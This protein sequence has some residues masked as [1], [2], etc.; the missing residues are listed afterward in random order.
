MSFLEIFGR[1]RNDDPDTSKEAA[2]SI[3]TAH[4]ELLVLGVVKRHKNGVI[5]EDV[6]RELAHIRSHSITPRFAQLIDKGLI[7]DTG[8]RRKASS[9]RNQRVVKATENVITN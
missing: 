7:Y 2:E 9:G 1:S 4:L 5:S 6:E 8:E 3:T